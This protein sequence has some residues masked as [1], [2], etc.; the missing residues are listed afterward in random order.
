[1][2]SLKELSGLPDENS[3]AF[4]YA[5]ALLAI[6]EEQGMEQEFFTQ[7]T[8]IGA[9]AAAEGGCLALF[10]GKGHLPLHQQKE[11]V[12]EV[13]AG[14]IHP[15]IENLLYLLLDKGRGSY[16]PSLTI[17]YRLLLDEKEGILP[18]TLISPRLLEPEQIANV[19]AAFA[20]IS[21]HKIRLSQ[22]ADPSLIGGLKLIIGDII[23]DGT[24]AM[25][26]DKLEDRLMN[27]Q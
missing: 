8:D 22:E 23:Y 9:A 1:M 15:M 19:A 16:L 18:A 2:I 13:F 20:G 14:Q 3:I 5:L 6:G 24:L 10:L 27:G 11:L 12:K 25:H 4:R 26:L 21:G 17:A 7:L